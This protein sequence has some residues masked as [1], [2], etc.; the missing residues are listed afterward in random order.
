MLAHQF[1]EYAVPGGF[2]GIGNIAMF[3]E[4][5]A[6][7]RYP[8]NANQVMISNVFLTYPFYVIPVFFP[9]LI[10][11]GFIQVGQGMVQIINHGI[12]TN[13]RMKTLYNPGLATVL[14]LQWPTGIYYI[15]FVS[16]HH[17]AMNSDY[18]F[19]LL[20]AFASTVVL[21]LGPIRL[22]RD[23]NSK[24]PF[25]EADMFKFMGRRLREM[26]ATPPRSE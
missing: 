26:L 11:L 7:D 20:G 23:R 16:A 9:D 5:L 25:R 17:L 2:Q 6:P 22:F 8:L 24:Y 21:W 4:R 15:Y 13:L 19:G 10:W 18:I 1:E 14:L 3:G 12:L